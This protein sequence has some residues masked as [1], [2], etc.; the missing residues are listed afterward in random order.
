MGFF[1]MLVGGAIIY[2]I[3]HNDSKRNTYR[4]EQQ[5]EGNSLSWQS[6]PSYH[7]PVCTFDSVLTREQF[8]RLVKRTAKSFRRIKE[9]TIDGAEIRGTALTNSGLNEWEFSIDFNDY[10]RVTGKYSIS[11]DNYESTLVDRFAERIQEEVNKTLDAA[12]PKLYF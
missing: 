4:Y 7:T 1:S 5:A 9:Y 2:R 8:C 11:T 6:M 10:G 12:V 3:L